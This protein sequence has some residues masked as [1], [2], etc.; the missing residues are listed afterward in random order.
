MPVKLQFLS[1]EDKE[2]IHRSSLDFLAN[3]GVPSMFG[4]I[5]GT[6]KEPVELRD[7]LRVMVVNIKIAMEII[8][9]GIQL[10]LHEEIN[11]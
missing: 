11:Q 10:D 8:R 9:S 6:V 1:K 2:Q 7:Y 5:L 3:T 4:L